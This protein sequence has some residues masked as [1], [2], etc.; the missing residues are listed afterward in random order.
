MTKRVG[1]TQRDPPLV[2]SNA[3]VV[4]FLGVDRGR[5]GMRLR[6]K[7]LAAHRYAPLNLLAAPIRVRG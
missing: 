3:R 6:D 5:G 2:V 7:T 1:S 4:V